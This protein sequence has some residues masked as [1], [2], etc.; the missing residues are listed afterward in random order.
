MWF[1]D[2]DGAHSVKDIRS[3]VQVDADPSSWS[4]DDLDLHPRILIEPE[5]TKETPR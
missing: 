3:G 2:A 4:P 1:V 5:P